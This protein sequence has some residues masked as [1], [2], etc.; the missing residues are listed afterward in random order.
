MI[1]QSD[2]FKKLVIEEKDT[3]KEMEKLADEAV[4]IFRIERPSGRIIFQDYGGLDHKQRISVL[5]MGKYF[6]NMFGLIE[7]PS[8]S[9]SEIAKELGQ[10][11]TSLSGPI[12]SLVKKGF[13]E[14][15]P[16]KKYRIAYHRIKEVISE[17]LLTKGE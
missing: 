7:N 4:K 14:K 2:I 17:V 5:L 16:E 1:E 15:L 13:V 8:L 6:A 9:I 12:K 11:M 10:P 3:T